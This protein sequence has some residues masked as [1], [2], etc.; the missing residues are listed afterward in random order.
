MIDRDVVYFAR[1]HWI[2]FFW[3]L[4]LAIF[5]LFLGTN[6]NQLHY[7]ALLFFAVALIWTLMTW[8]TYHFSSVTIKKKQVIL[9]T[10]M[11]VRQTVDIPMSKIETIDIRQSILGSIF[12][13]G[14]LVITGTGGTRHI[15]N[16]LANPLTCR[17]YI[18][19]LMHD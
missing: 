18:E 16:F 10:G 17:R 2:L 4:L 3:P 5:A 13:Y 1:L 6:V 11:L 19:Q 9:R 7:V 15:I 12:R 14:S 8:V